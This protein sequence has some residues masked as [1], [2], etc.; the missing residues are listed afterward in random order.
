MKYNQAFIEITLTTNGYKS[1]SRAGKDGLIDA[2]IASI[3]YYSRLRSPMPKHR[4]FEKLE[5]GTQN[6]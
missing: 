6:L 2:A 1:Y 3:A 5:S 4:D